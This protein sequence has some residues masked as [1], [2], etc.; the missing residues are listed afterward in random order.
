MPVLNP[1]TFI[2]GDYEPGLFFVAA[3]GLEEEKEGGKRC[4]ACFRLRLKKAAEE[5]KKIGARYFA[6]TL[7]VSPHKSTPLIHRV[8]EEIERETG[9]AY[10]RG[11][12]EKGRV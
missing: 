10:L 3:A 12:Q 1:L 8:G 6:T 2:E 5:A 7:S 4:A 11:F 9:V